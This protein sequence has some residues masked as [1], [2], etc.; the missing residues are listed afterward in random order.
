M[1]KH[2]VRR[3]GFALT[4]VLVCAPTF[5]FAQKR[6]AKEISTELS[7]LSREIKRFDFASQIDPRFR[8][9]MTGELTAQ[10]QQHLKLVDELAAASPVEKSALRPVKARD[11]AVLA[12]FEDAEA[13]KQ[14]EELKQSKV[15][16]DGA[17]G[18]IASLQLAWWAKPKADEQSKVLE[19]IKTFAKANPTEDALTS[20]MLDIANAGAANDEL[21]ESLRVSIETD[22]KGPSAQKYKL[23]PDKLGRPLVISGV[24]VQGKPFTSASLKGKVV[25][26]DFWATWCGPCREALPELIEFYKQNKEKGLE[27]IG[28]SCDS[29]KQD[30]L[31]F[32]K[33]TPDM[34]WP[35]LYGPSGSNG[36]HV[37]AA[38]FQVTSVP[39]MYVI[40]REGILRRIEN[41]RFPKAKIQKLI[42]GPEKAAAK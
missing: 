37:L 42:D 21:A 40:D 4:V 2:L 24:T 19:E 13:I 6:P 31:T 5:V 9:Q 12:L 20:A 26:V 25:I 8:Q 33:E 22:L 15:P 11:L 35:N 27:V 10:Y 17:V 34:S 41:G 3:L 1:S 38:K 29:K 18:R 16:A 14:I 36:W 32:L 23:R 30:L 39:T 28:V 7:Q